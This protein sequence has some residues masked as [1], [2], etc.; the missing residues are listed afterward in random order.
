MKHRYITLSTSLC[1][2][3]LGLQLNAF[4]AEER[5][6]PPKGELQRVALAANLVEYGTKHDDPI[7]L[8]SAVR[9]YGTIAG[10]VKDK[11][12]AAVNIDNL[13]NRAEVLAREDPAAAHIKGLIGEI[14]TKSK[15]WS[16]VPSQCHEYA[17]HCDWAGCRYVYVYFPC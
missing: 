6:E 4:A 3:F 10:K 12:G 1:I 16:W 13:V 9:I 14:R 5:P 7:A 15:G 8:L 11:K 2:A 17:W